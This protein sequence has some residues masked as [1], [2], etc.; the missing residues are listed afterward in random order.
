VSEEKEKLKMMIK[1]F[2]LDNQA[3]IAIPSLRVC[4][5]NN[6]KKWKGKLSDI[7]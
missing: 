2:K 5:I 3:Y 7:L 6:I 4:V 1:R